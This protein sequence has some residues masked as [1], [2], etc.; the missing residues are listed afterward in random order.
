MNQKQLPKT[1]ATINETRQALGLSGPTVY[2]LT[3][4][5]DLTMVKVVKS[6]R[7]TWESIHAFLAR[8]NQES[9]R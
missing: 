4:R 7:W 9:A 5:G 6:S 3:R 2:A 1:L 8:R